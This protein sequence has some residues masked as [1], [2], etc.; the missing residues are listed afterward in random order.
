MPFIKSTDAGSNGG[1]KLGAA[2]GDDEEFSIDFGGGVEIA[3]GRG[4][5]DT[6]ITYIRLKNADGESA[7]VFPNATQDGITVQSTR[8]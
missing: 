3:F 5:T 2:S 4:T 8:P 7:Y 1:F 6:D